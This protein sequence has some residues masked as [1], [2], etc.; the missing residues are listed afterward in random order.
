MSGFVD[1][2][3]SVNYL[4]LRHMQNIAAGEKLTGAE[5]KVTCPEYPEL[6]ILV[7]TAQIPAM[8]RADV[9]DFGGMGMKFTQH[10]AFENS[11][12]MTIS[13][14]ETISGAIVR[15]LRNVIKNK[16]YLTLSFEAT[17]ESTIGI[18]SPFHKFKLEHCKI[19]SDVIEFSTEDTS[20]LVKPSMTVVYNWFDL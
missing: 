15:I 6:S 5:F 7:R 19:R 20:A 10:G 3:G 18:G 17:P 8:G 4:K 12:E 2:A 13:A 14:V 16:E 9:E 11:G 1:A